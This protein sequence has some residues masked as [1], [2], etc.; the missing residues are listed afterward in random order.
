MGLRVKKKALKLGH[1]FN[2]LDGGNLYKKTGSYH[3]EN[4]YSLNL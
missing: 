2:F 4:Q 3:K 1:I